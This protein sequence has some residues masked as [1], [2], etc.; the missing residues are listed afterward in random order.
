[1]QLLPSAETER[2]GQDSA[3]HEDPLGGTA[4]VQKAA[5]QVASPGAQS[6]NLDGSPSSVPSYVALHARLGT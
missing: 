3:R 5:T 2:T 4:E 6:G 1:M